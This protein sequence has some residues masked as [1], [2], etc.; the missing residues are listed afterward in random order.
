[1]SARTAVS[2][3]LLLFRRTNASRGLEVF[4]AHP[5]GPFW[6]K[7]DLGAW[8]IPKGVVDDGEDLL[9]GAR[10]EF[11][12][13][14]G[15]EAPG[16]FIPLGAIKQKAGKIVHAW[17][18][19]GDADPSAATSNTTRTEWPRGS[20]KWITYPEVDRCGWFDLAAARAKMIAAQA[21]FVDRLEKTI[22][23]G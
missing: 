16:P 5:G 12:E 4:L 3:G 22:S 11:R 23:D 2:S 21:E 15:I 19:E 20:G 7:R 9:D 10:R 14:T 1:V 18:W 6:A 13:E 8:T 17:A